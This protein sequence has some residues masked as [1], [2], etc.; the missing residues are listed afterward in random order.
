MRA[1][2]GLTVRRLRALESSRAFDDPA[3]LAAL[4][5]QVVEGL[6]AFEFALRRA[7]GDQSQ[8]APTLGRSG[9]VPAGYRRA[10]EEYYRG[11]ARRGAP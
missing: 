8:D 6:K 2:T 5:G 3:E 10:V 7:L 4:Q 11:L 9:E 1:A